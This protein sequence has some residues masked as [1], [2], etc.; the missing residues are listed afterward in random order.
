MVYYVLSVAFAVARERDSNCKQNIYSF[1]LNRCI[2]SAMDPWSCQRPWK[3]R[4]LCKEGEG[5]GKESGG[6]GKEWKSGQR[7]QFVGKVVILLGKDFLIIIKGNRW[8]TAWRLCSV[9]GRYC[10]GN[11][12]WSVTHEP[13]QYKPFKSTKLSIFKS[14]TF[15][16]MFL[17]N[18]VSW[19]ISIPRMWAFNVYNSNIEKAC[20]SR[21]L[22]LT[23]Y[24]RG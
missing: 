13:G 16:M 21:A 23:G 2:L 22:N 18:N 19:I 10:S 6:L 5:L 24:M 15:R 9:A 12:A 11:A 4:R 3:H 8:Q 1:H 20:C 7:M 14:T 17:S